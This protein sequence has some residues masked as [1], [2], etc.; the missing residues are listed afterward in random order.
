MTWPDKYS[1]ADTKKPLDTRVSGDMPCS[2]RDAGKGENQST[3][4]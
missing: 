2:K 3:L 1:P 4:K